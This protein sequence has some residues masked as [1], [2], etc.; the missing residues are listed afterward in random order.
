MFKSEASTVNILKPMMEFLIFQTE[1]DS[2]DLKSI[3]FKI[4]TMVSK[5]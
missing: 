1:E 2:V 4:C 5:L 3:L